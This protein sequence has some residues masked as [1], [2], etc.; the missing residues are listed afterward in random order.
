MIANRQNEVTKLLLEAAAT[1]SQSIHWDGIPAPTWSRSKGFHL[2][3]SNP[4]TDLL[5]RAYELISLLSVLE[6]QST[7]LRDCN[8]GFQ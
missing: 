1:W 6:L 8:R 3:K 4:R 5:R 2:H 7:Y